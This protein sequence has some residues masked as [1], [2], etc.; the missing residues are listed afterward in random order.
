MSVF[1]PSRL[2]LLTTLRTEEA[3]RAVPTSMPGSRSNLIIMGDDGISVSFAM[4]VLP[5]PEY[6]DRASDQMR[7]CRCRSDKSA[8]YTL[9]VGG[10]KER[11]FYGKS[12]DSGQFRDLGAPPYDVAIKGYC[13][14]WQW[15]LVSA[16]IRHHTCF[17][18]TTVFMG[19]NLF[20]LRPAERDWSWLKA[21][22]MPNLCYHFIE[23]LAS[24][25]KWSR[26]EYVKDRKARAKKTCSQMQRA[27]CRTF[28]HCVNI[29]I[30]QLPS[31][32]GR[33]RIDYSTCTI[34]SLR[35]RAI[36]AL[37][38]HEAWRRLE[39]APR[40]AHTIP[41]PPGFYIRRLVPV[42]W[43]RFVVLLATKDILIQD[44][45]SG[46][47]NRVP[48][49]GCPV[50]AL[51]SVRVFWVESIASNVLVAHLNDTGTQKLS[52]FKLDIQS[53]LAVLLIDVAAPDGLVHL[54]L[55]GTD[56]AV[57]CAVGP[58]VHICTFEMVLVPEVVVSPRTVLQI[59]TQVF[60][61]LVI[62]SRVSD[63][64][65]K[66]PQQSV[67]LILS[68]DRFLVASSVGISIF[69]IPAEA[70]EHTLH[71][72]WLTPPLWQY[73]YNHDNG[74]RPPRLPPLIEDG[75]GKM[76]LSIPS[77]GH[78]RVLTIPFKSS[79]FQISERLLGSRLPNSALG[80][81]IGVY[82]HPAVSRFVTFPHGADSK[83][84]PFSCEADDKERLTLRVGSVIHVA[85]EACQ[86]LEI[87]EG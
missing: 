8:I 11:D 83:D 62:A 48:L 28:W 20:T 34:D 9:P 22:M 14:P 32:P 77:G 2:V 31:A 68:W 29:D 73:K 54:D 19:R 74:S 7:A 33:P 16:Q 36:K 21:G 37:L 78:F 50:L 35:A 67:F 39:H 10:N 55:Q 43:S 53:G 60:L 30:D 71:R 65:Q 79:G 82:R 5:V 17:M 41:S 46:H 23:V 70:L 56:L 76:F 44:W 13:W 6:S 15:F 49:P 84:H 87:D 63:L 24:Q 64:T 47:V 66:T 51:Y 58:L 40:I 59:V 61:L 42:P 80:V 52:F 18:A 45:R 72:N 38:V 69:E 26:S 27:N 57:L 25:A 1:S 85:L 81:R 86:S 3:A 4:P 75:N 12:R